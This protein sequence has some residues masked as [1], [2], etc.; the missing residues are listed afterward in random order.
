MRDVS[1]NCHNEIKFFTSR[2][3]NKFARDSLSIAL[4]FSKQSVKET[5]LEY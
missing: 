3:N 4:T 2:L 1:I 5:L